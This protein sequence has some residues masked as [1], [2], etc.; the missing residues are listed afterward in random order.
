MSYTNLRDFL[1][2]VCSCGLQLNLTTSETHALGCTT[3]GEWTVTPV[4]LLLDS[5][6]A[7]IRCDLWSLSPEVSLSAVDKSAELLNSGF[8]PAEWPNIP[9]LILAPK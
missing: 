8:L 4:G 9:K 5:L 3:K 1:F 7:L 6:F 2:S